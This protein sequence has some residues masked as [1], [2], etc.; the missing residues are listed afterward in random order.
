MKLLDDRYA[1]ITNAI[2]FLEAQFSAVVEADELW[3]KSIG[4]YPGQHQRGDLAA[5]LNTL[6]PLTGPQVRYIWIKT[7]SGWTSYFDNFLNG[8]DPFGPISYL[9]GVLKCRGVTVSYRPQNEACEGGASFSLFGAGQTDWL[10]CIRSISAINEG[11]RWRWDA[12]GM[13][14]PFEETER[15][16]ARRI[17]DRLTPDM[18]E[19]YCA[20]LGIRPVDA[21]YYQKDGYLV[22]NKNTKCPVRTESLLQARER[23]NFI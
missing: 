21:S 8:S 17:R 11:G 7:C 10:N 13:V 15:Y 1:P 14:Q 16:Q 5:L 3:R 2:G 19:R 12:N 22:E 18:I 4:V 23:F 9:A 6:L 20:S